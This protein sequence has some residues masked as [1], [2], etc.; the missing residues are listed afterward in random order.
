MNPMTPNLR[1]GLPKLHFVIYGAGSER[2]IRIG[3]TRWLLCGECCLNPEELHP[4]PDPERHLCSLCAERISASHVAGSEYERGYADGESSMM[5]DW[6]FALAEYTALEDS[7][8][9]ME[10]AHYIHDLEVQNRKVRELWGEILASF[11]G[12]ERIP[13]TVPTVSQE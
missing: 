11:H 3:Q 8:S 4:S 5:A 2:H 13:D 10:A 9:P 6:S 12:L 7:P 1:S